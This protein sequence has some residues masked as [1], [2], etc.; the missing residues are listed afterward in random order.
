MD[1]LFE[2]EIEPFDCVG[3]LLVLT[4]IDVEL[5]LDT[6]FESVCRWYDWVVDGSS[7]EGDGEAD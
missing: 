6:T 3:V 1:G 7:T 5:D 2:G 4:E